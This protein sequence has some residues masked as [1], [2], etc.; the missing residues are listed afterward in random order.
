MSS[1]TLGTD[2]T[3][4]ITRITG[5]VTLSGTVSGSGV[6]IVDGDI[7]VT[8]NFTFNG[9]VIARGDVEVEIF[10]SAS[11]FGGLMIGG[12]G[13]GVDP[14]FEL[15]MRGNAKVCYST[16]GLAKADAVGPNIRPAPTKLIAWHEKL[17]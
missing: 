12:V 3:P 17:S 2:L 7:T 13:P 16:Q 8:D 11:I 15:D 5:N 6:L 14:A 4:R 9:L 1:G 10:G